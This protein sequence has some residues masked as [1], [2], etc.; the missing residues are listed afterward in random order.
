MDTFWV[1]EKVCGHVTVSVL[2]A[3]YNMVK[4]Y[5]CL[6]GSHAGANVHYIRQTTL[7]KPTVVSLLIVVCSN[8]QLKPAR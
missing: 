1:A 6:P 5:K 7:F 4:M 2:R 3:E 8:H